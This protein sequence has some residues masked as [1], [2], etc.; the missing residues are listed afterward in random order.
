V[1]LI[2]VTYGN[3]DLQNCLRNII[4]LFHYVDKEIAWRESVGRSLGFETLRKSK[5]VVAIGPE[6]PLAE[7]ALMADFFRK[8]N[9]WMSLDMELILATDGQDGLGGIHLSVCEHVRG[10]VEFY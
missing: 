1:L 5:P 7:N 2:S 4:L 10:R 9:C 3:I 8:S 6:H